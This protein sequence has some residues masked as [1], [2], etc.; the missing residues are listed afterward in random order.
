VTPDNK[1]GVIYP[2]IVAHKKILF[3]QTFGEDDR[4]D[5]RDLFHF[6]SAEARGGAISAQG[7]FYRKEEEW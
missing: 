5:A 4:R 6:K 3:E 1:I 2:A 7:F